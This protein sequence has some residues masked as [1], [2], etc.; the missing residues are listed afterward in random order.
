MLNIVLRYRFIAIRI[1]ILFLLFTWGFY[2]SRPRMVTA[3]SAS[4]S[5]RDTPAVAIPLELSVATSVIASKWQ[6]L[7]EP[8]AI[9]FKSWTERYA[10]AASHTQLELVS[11]G[12]TLAAARRD[13]LVELILKDPEQALAEAIPIVVRQNLPAQVIAL[14]ETRVSGQGSITNQVSTPRRGERMK[15]T[16]RCRA[17]LNGKSYNAFTYG[18]RARMGYLPKV[19]IN[20]IVL[21]DKLAVSDSPVRTLEQG[22]PLPDSQ[23]VGPCTAPSAIPPAV[24]VEGRVQRLCCAHHLTRLAARLVASEGKQANGA[25]GPLDESGKLTSAWTSG[26][27]K[28]LIVRLEFSDV[29]GEPIDD[30]GLPLTPTRVVDLINGPNQTKDF[31]E[32]SSYGKTTLVI[33]PVVANVSPDVTSLLLMPRTLQSYASTFNASTSDIGDVEAMYADAKILALPKGYDFDNYDRVIIAYTSAGRFS[34]SRMKFGGLA[35]TPGARLWVN[36]IFDL[37]FF[38]HELGHNY[39]LAHADR[40]IVTDGN[41]VSPNGSSEE[42]GDVFDMMGEGD[43]I[44]L[45]I[46]HDFSPWS[47]KHLQ[48]LPAAAVTTVTQSGTYRV[49]RFDSKG[50]NLANTL[51]L[52]VAHNSTQ[53]YWISYKRATNNPNLQNG[54]YIMWAANENIIPVEG[55]NSSGLLLDMTTPGDTPNDCAL[56]VGQTFN[57]SAKAIRFKTVA[58]GGSGIDEYLDI[59][60]IFGNDTAYQTWRSV[61]FTTTELSNDTISGDLADPDGDGLVNLLEFALNL[62]PKTSGLIGGPTLSTLTL[63]N[64]SYLTLTFRR[65]LVA[66]ELTYLPETSGTLTADWAGDAVLVGNPISNSDGTETVTY[67]DSVPITSAAKRFMRLKVS[68]TP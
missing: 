7:E 35:E 12:V 59:Q 1:I 9:A 5:A 40:W 55:V 19:S 34:N 30:A 66:P 28:V 8:S 38:A 41:P 31:F 33:A 43:G 16:H 6:K 49:Y 50:A 37:D 10:A 39:G 52:K 46:T 23:V 45:D 15:Q 61:K 56:A 29:L 26:P 53:D 22:E 3:T 21:D 20:G 58:R 44:A 63:N 62:P 27:K 42:Y 17:Y 32:Q 47:K 11:E 4:V 51:A 68:L 14:L 60:V 64:D 25:P 57:D 2:Q 65:Q 13:C 48:W 36:G 18:R 54:A 24:E 67:R